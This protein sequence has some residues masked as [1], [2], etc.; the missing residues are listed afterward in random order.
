MHTYSQ[1]V[2]AQR[3]VKINVTDLLE[4]LLE[5]FFDREDELIKASYISPFDTIA[6][7][8][9]KILSLNN[10]A[11]SEVMKVLEKYNYHAYDKTLSKEEKQRYVFNSLSGILNELDNYNTILFYE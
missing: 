10:D 3:D 8:T 11:K 7:Y 6:E 9:A 5:S 1:R 4:S 2:L